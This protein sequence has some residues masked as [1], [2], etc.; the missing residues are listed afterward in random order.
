MTARRR[1]TTTDDF[2]ATVRAFAE[3]QTAA[4]RESKRAT[5]EAIQRTQ[6]ELAAFLTEWKALGGTISAIRYGEPLPGGGTPIP[7]EKWIEACSYELHQ[8]QNKKGS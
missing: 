3:A 7:A 1:S 5:W 8:V 4:S 2:T 6:P